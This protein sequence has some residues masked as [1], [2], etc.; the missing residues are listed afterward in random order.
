MP[1]LRQQILRPWR[2]VARVQQRR[3]LSNLQRNRHCAHRE[4]RRARARRKQDHR[5]GRRGG[6]GH[7]HVGPHEAG[8][9][10]YGRAHERAVL[11]AHGR[12]TRHRLQRAGREEAH[13]LQ[14]EEGREFRRTRLHLLQCRAHR[15]KLPR[16]GERRE[17]LAPRGEILDGR[18]LPRLRR[19]APVRGHARTNRSRHQSGSGDENDTR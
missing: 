2:R 1:A 5:R 6:M 10:R 3:S 18:P 8:V 11:R 19:H 7:A 14:G 15:G 9:R 4:P 17:G 12:R 16:Q 13:P